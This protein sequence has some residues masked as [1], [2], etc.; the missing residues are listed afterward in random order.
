[1]GNYKLNT[2]LINDWRLYVDI[3]VLI[4]SEKCSNVVMRNVCVHDC[5]IENG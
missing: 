1:M 4:D 5:V 3:V 2:Y